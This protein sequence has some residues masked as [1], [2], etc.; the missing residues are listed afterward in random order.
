[1][2]TD[3]F[4][5]SAAIVLL[6]LAAAFASS[7][8]ATEPIAIAPYHIDPSGW[9][10]V[11]VTVNDAGPF[12]FIIDTGATRSIVFSSLAA[13]MAFPDSELPPQRVIGITSSALHPTFIVGE[14][15]IGEAKMSPLVTVV[16]EDWR[17]G[18]RAPLGV[19][20]LDFLT[21]Y[22]IEFD[23][24]TGEMRLYEP[25]E[26]RGLDMRRWRQVPLQRDD[27]GLNSGEMFVLAGMVDRKP[28][29]LMLD[30]GANV[31]IVN[32]HVFEQRDT[33][34]P[35]SA[36]GVQ[37][38]RYAARII[39]A[40]EESAAG[41]RVII[42]DLQAGTS[43]WNDLNIVVHNASVFEELGR[44]EEPFGL[45]GA[46]MLTGRSFVLD[47]AN[48]LLLVSRSDARGRGDRSAETRYQFCTSAYDCR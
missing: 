20:G 42:R 46:D 23:A 34:R 19:I 32:S 9:F 31:T 47:F 33:R 17:P 10:I 24:G 16:L 25:G 29:D 11:D 3:W 2:K 1:M 27:F 15:A 14:L 41:V 37:R 26:A 13:Q 48:D 4:S 30:L 36:V 22:R 5:V 8:R 44:A 21:R 38:D 7:A 45:F 35:R 39:D 43:V 6:A 18:L 40:L 28:A 12:P